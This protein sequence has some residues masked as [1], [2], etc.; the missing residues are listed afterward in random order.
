MAYVIYHKE[1]TLILRKRWYQKP[2]ETIGAAKAGLTRACR[3]DP[4][5]V[6][7]EYDIADTKTFHEKIEKFVER[8]NLLS[9]E[10]IQVRVNEPACTDPSTE[11]YWSM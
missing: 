4:K 2:Y 1:S 6:R 9:R 3:K 5:L 7:E 11:T 8:K 10:P